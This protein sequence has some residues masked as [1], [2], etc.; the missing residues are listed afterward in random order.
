M[1]ISA[2]IP[3]FNEEDHI[4]AA[5]ESLAWADE[6]IVVDSFSTDNTVALA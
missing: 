4:I 1:K 2:I 5:I 3:T 6:I